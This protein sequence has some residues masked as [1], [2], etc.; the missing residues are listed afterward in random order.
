MLINDEGTIGRMLSRAISKIAQDDSPSNAD[1]LRNVS[2][3]KTDVLSGSDVGSEARRLFANTTAYDN[4]IVAVRRALAKGTP[5]INVVCRG[6]GSEPQKALTNLIINAALVDP[7]TMEPDSPESDK[8]RRQRMKS[9]QNSIVG[10]RYFHYPSNPKEAE[11]SQKELDRQLL[12]ET[13]WDPDSSYNA[14]L[15][16]QIRDPQNPNSLP[17]G[18][19]LPIGNLGDGML[20]RPDDIICDPDSP[21]SYLYPYLSETETS[22]GS[23]EAAAKEKRK[24][25]RQTIV[26]HPD[27]VTR[28]VS[29]DDRLLLG[30]AANQMNHFYHSLF[31]IQG[32][33]TGEGW[34]FVPYNMSDAAIYGADN[35]GKWGNS[36]SVASA[37]KFVNVARGIP[38]IDEIG[39]FEDILFDSD[40]P[41]E[42]A[43]SENTGEIDEPPASSAFTLENVKNCIE[44]IRRSAPDIGAEG[45]SR[46]PTVEQVVEAVNGLADDRVAA[47]ISESVSDVN[48]V[49]ALAAV[50]SNEFEEWLNTIPSNNTIIRRVEPLKS[51]LE[52]S[53]EESNSPAVNE[54]EVDEAEPDVIRDITEEES[55]AISNL[56]V[57]NILNQ[58]VEVNRHIESGQRV[59]RQ[60]AMLP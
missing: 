5:I 31:N 19:V 21:D 8:D 34:R 36:E 50:L 45:V 17:T 3:C 49:T 57:Q 2:A 25:L 6:Y 10:R 26:N 20:L 13:R 15:A 55:P 48:M 54:T 38:P 30:R 40:E 18:D 4:D 41:V 42:D 44:W 59:L 29:D 14:V 24:E 52:E 22:I 28:D 7:P 43:V 47:I 39:D 60:R 53:F 23:L 46:F 32:F 56:S 12:G 58:H 1:L 27:R 35:V 37:S 33:G 9:L 51:G 16:F 11:R